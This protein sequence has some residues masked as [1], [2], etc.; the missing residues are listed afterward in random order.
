MEF[1]WGKQNCLHLRP[2]SDMVA[3]E[4]TH[5]LLKPKSPAAGAGGFSIRTN[6]TNHTFGALGCGRCEELG[7]SARN[8][9][10][11]LARPISP[12]GLLHLDHR[13]RPSVNL[14][15]IFRGI[16]DSDSLANENGSDLMRARGT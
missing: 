9:E 13:H 10:Y 6:D 7:F 3:T 11:A 14:R 12:L 5:E 1:Y 2:C 16:T 8:A 15:K 4:E